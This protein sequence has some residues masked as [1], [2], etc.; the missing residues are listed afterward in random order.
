[1]KLNP[2]EEHI[3]NLV[4]NKAISSLNSNTP[5]NFN[6]LVDEIKAYLIDF[7][8]KHELS[9]IRHAKILKIKRT[10]FQLIFKTLRN[11]GKLGHLYYKGLSK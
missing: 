2:A 9:L 8:W 5:V 11:K 4:L 7:S 10:T 3:I 6:E 1:M